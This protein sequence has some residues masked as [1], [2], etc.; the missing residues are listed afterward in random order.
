MKFLI[1]KTLNEVDLFSGSFSNKKAISKKPFDVKFNTESDIENF[2]NHVSDY[3]ESNP[4][5]ENN[6][7]LYNHIL[8]NDKGLLNKAYM[9]YIG[10]MKTP[11][12]DEN[13]ILGIYNAIKGGN[14][15]GDEEWFKRAVLTGPQSL[16]TIV[17]LVNNGSLTGQEKWLKRNSL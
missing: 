10:N 14:I 16:Y 6:K 4:N 7:K 13:T 8:F 15:N 12:K 3:I 17:S 5:L 11:V 1:E 9:N 2:K